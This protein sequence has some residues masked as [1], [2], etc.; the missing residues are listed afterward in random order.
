MFTKLIEKLEGRSFSA[1]VVQSILD[2]RKY[3]LSKKND[4]YKGKES[5]LGR[6]YKYLMDNPEKIISYP[7][8]EAFYDGMQVYT[9]NDQNNRNQKVLIYFY[10]SAYYR[11]VTNLHLKKLKKIIDKTGVKI[12]LPNYHK[13]YDHNFKQVL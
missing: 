3:K 9:I 10:G 13:A 1:I 2:Y 5:F 12:I 7:V 8:K 4:P 6:K 11:Q